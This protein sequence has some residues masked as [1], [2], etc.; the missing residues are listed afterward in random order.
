MASPL[1][2]VRVLE[3]ANWIAVPSA[4]AIMADLGADVIKVEPPSGDSM[5]D[6]LR[7]PHLPGEDEPLDCAFQLDN[8]GKRSIAIALEEPRGQRL[9]HRLIDRA[10]VLT[11]NLLP[12]R[13]SRYRLCPG[14]AHALNPRLI[15]ASLTAFG[16]EGEEAD[17]TGFDHTAFFARGGVS[18]LL[19]EPEGPPHPL[20][21]GQGDHMASLNLL[22]AVLAALRLRDQTGEGQTIETSL[23]RT[24]AWFAGSDLAPTLV[25]RSPPPRS[26]RADVVNPLANTFRC[27]DGRWIKLQMGF[28]KPYWPSFCKALSHPEWEQDPRFATYARRAENREPL[29]ELIEQVFTGAPRA[30]WGERLNQAGMVWAPVAELHEVVEDP[31]VRA[32]GTFAEIEHPRAGRF[33]TVDTP[34][35]IVGADVAVRGPAPDVGQHSSEILR[36]LGLEEAEIADLARDGI[37][38]G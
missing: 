14:D 12:R 36:E 22:A 28:P 25:D 34:F 8:R 11:T 10:D 19:S 13:Q 26:G 6:V 2:G 38:A 29:R 9:V 1:T 18:S 32:I 21:P 4:G 3:V 27:G 24:S 31:Q 16:H 23:L 7:K 5:R 30:E 17:Q 15:Y 37:V 20:R 35:R 33:E